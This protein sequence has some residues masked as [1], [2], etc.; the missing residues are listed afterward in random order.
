MPV[1]REYTQRVQTPGPSR[2]DIPNTEGG[3]GVATRRLAESVRSVG[4]VV[5]KRA[6]QSEVSTLNAQMAE[7][8]ERYT[9]KWRETLKTAEPGDP[10]L[11][12]TFMEDFEK[13]VQPLGDEYSTS[14]GRAQFQNSYARLHL[15]FAST[16]DAGQAELAGV[17]ARNDY[18][19]TVSG[20]SSSLL[21]DPSSFS[22]SLENHNNAVDNL[23]NSGLLP[24]FEADKLKQEGSRTLAKSTVRGWIDLDAKSAEQE[25]NSGRWDQ[26]LDGDLKRQLLG[27]AKQ[28]IRAA[29]VEEERRKAEAK[30]RLEE[31]QTI[32]QNKLL[33]KLT[34][35][36]LT[37]DDILKSN[38]DPFGSGGKSQFLNMIQENLSGGVRKDPATMSELYRRIHLDDGDPQKIVDEKDLYPYFSKLGTD[39]MQAL[40]NEIQGKGTQ[41]GRIEGELKSQLLKIAEQK[42][43]KP[44][45]GGYD[46]GG[47]ENYIRY[48]D[49][50][51]QELLRQKKAGKSYRQLLVP[52]S[53]DYLGDL[54]SNFTKTPQ[55]QMEALTRQRTPVT[56]PPGQ[57]QSVK[58]NPGESIEAYNK[59]TGMGK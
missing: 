50:I 26:F 25:I 8:Q 17:K 34:K 4:D 28:G 44:S 45:W 7:V 3:V 37:A 27:E 47:R 35:N 32:T 15:H 40:R 21:N 41:E 48:M 39:G 10:T 24:R 6:E 14:A 9:K 51:N 49:F 29:E 53:P 1:I 22:L 58:R 11:A 42:L 43:V 30:A 16:A 19:T 56:T 5:N 38:L 52:G 13:E 20:L 59:R 55:Q 31:Q 23:V 18:E 57:T 54:I 2:A 12:Q 46:A 33:E 36:Q